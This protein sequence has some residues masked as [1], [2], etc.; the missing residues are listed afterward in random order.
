[1]IVSDEK[2]TPSKGWI[3]FEIVSGAVLG[4]IGWGLHYGWFHLGK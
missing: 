4:L 3:I 2:R 1:M